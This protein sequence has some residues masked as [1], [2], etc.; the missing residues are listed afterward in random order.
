MTLEEL[1]IVKQSLKLQ[2]RGCTCDDC[3]KVRKA[4]EAIDREIRLKELNPVTG[5]KKGK[6]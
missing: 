6:T 4:H 1:Q 3:E 5:G 2:P